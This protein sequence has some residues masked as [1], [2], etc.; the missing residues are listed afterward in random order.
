VTDSLNN[1][2]QI[3]TADG[4]FLRT[5]RQGRG[6]PFGVAADSSGMVYVSDCTRHNISVFTPDGNLMTSLGTMGEVPGKFNTPHGL[7]VGSDGSLYVC[8]SRNSRIQV[9]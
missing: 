7:A 4:T 9:F 8:D 3:F 6:Q 5:L 2:T 1:C